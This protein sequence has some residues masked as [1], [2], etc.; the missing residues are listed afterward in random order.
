MKK[1]SHSVIVCVEEE[2]QH[3][4]KQVAM[5]FLPS[6][7]TLFLL[8]G[9]NTERR[10]GPLAMVPLWRYHHLPAEIPFLGHTSQTGGLRALSWCIP[11]DRDCTLHGQTG[12]TTL[13]HAEKLQAAST[14]WHN[15]LVFD[16]YEEWLPWYM[17]ELESSRD[18]WEA[19]ICISRWN[20]LK[21]LRLYDSTILITAN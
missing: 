1:E 17:E 14:K 8:T 19:K 9:S 11:H 18:D 12:R 3:R 2:P 13:K 4:L 10:F 21:I 7:S 6:K 20:V 5:P 15:C 16:H